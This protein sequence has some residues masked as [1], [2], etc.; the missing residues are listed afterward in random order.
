MKRTLIWSIFFAGLIPS[1]VDEPDCVGLNNN[2]VGI[3]FRNLADGT[4]APVTF[5]K[6]RA[7]EEG[8]VFLTDETVSSV[9]LPL[10]FLEQSTTFLFEEP[11]KTSRLVLD[12]T[13]K[14]QFVSE[15]C[16][17][18][19]VLDNLSIRQHDFDSVRLLSRVPGTGSGTHIE[20]FR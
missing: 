8:V 1:C 12:Y 7:E 15:D 3:S 9:N 19:F 6:V 20:I 18:R 2:I 4:A 10:D 17:E 13:T 11:D 14:V 5:T 16:G